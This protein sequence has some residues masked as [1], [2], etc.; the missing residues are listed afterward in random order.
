VYNVSS[1]D[2]KI[3]SKQDKL[4]SSYKLFIDRYFENKN[5]MLIKIR[6]YAPIFKNLFNN[7]WSEHA[8]HSN[9][10]HARI[11]NITFGLN[12]T[13]IIPYLLFLKH[14]Y[15]NSPSPDD[16]EKMYI[17]LESYIMRRI[18]TKESQKNNNNFFTST[19]IGSRI[20]LPDDLVRVFNN[21]GNNTTKFPNNNELVN[22]FINSKLS[23]KQ[24]LG[25]LY[26]L[27]SQLRS[28][29]YTTQLKPMM[30]YQLEHLLPKKWR[31]HWT[32]GNP[33]DSDERDRKLLTLGNLS[34]ISET[35]NKSIGD[36]DWKIKIN[37]NANYGGLLTYASGLN[38]IQKYLNKPIWD[39]PEIQ[40][41][42]HDLIKMAL[43]VWPSIYLI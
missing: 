14:Y 31:N 29:R 12:N 5:E 38:T 34:L 21:Q 23:N 6:E 17:F 8:I 4:F 42:A 36:K 32:I 25:V 18:V 22:G 9:Q 28:E 40:N 35:L 16:I 11:I 30:Q 37:G 41:R 19:L 24:A 20:V 15:N 1:D 33:N 3:F 26:L 7:D 13:T 2:K 27:E 10:F 39:E 43:K